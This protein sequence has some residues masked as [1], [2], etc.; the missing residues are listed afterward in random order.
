MKKTLF[1]TAFLSLFLFTFFSCEEIKIQGIVDQQLIYCDAEKVEEKAGKILFINKKHYFES[2]GSQSSIKSHSGKFS[3][4]A[5]KKSP[6]AMAIKLKN[7]PKGS[8]VETSIW[9]LAQTFAN[10]QNLHFILGRRI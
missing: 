2:G 6:Y 9:K 1:K 8:Y 10:T 4:K 5:D 3:C 7:I